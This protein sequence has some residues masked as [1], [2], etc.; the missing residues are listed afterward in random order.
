MRTGQG[1]F[2]ILVLEFVELSCTALPRP[3]L[4]IFLAI[5]LAIL[6]AFCWRGQRCF[7]NYRGGSDDMGEFESL[8]DDD[9]VN[10]MVTWTYHT[11]FPHVS[12]YYS[13]V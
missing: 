7:D 10:E 11:I 4:A 13:P 5:L 6:L 3:V 1:K 12:V 9:K 2:H 8:S